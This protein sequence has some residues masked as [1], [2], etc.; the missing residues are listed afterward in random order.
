MKIVKSL[1]VAILFF[2]S[3]AVHAQQTVVPEA[4]GPDVP[5]A[6]AKFFGSWVGDWNYV[7]RQWL[8]V[9]KVG[10]S[11]T[12]QYSYLGTKAEPK[13]NQYYLSSI[14]NGVLAIRCGRG[15]TCSFKVHGDDLWAR[16][17]DTDNKTNNA[18]FVKE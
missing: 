8:R 17:S 13:P 18:V 15:G 14:E 6:C 12:V 16:Y 9:V 2:A 5:A 7:G 1:F 4:P 3:A 11:C 10:A